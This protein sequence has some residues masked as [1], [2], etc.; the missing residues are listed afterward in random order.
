MFILSLKACTLTQYC[1]H[2]EPCPAIWCCV[3]PLCSLFCNERKPALHLLGNFFF[4]IQISLVMLPLSQARS[5]RQTLLSSQGLD[6]SPTVSPLSLPPVAMSSSGQHCA[7]LDTVCC[8]FQVLTT[9][10]QFL[11]HLCPLWPS[12]VTDSIVLTQTKSAVFSRS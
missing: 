6:N 10:N 4:C 7:R 5:P 11:H 9:A 2:S 1:L 12:L 8:L 3:P